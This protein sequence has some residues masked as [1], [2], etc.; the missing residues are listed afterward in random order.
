MHHA[1]RWAII[2][3]FTVFLYGCSSQESVS[4]GEKVKS[5]VAQKTEKDS[6]PTYNPPEYK[7]DV[8]YDPP[9]YNVDI[10]Y[11]PPD[12]QVPEYH[13]PNFTSEVKVIQPNEHQTWIRIPDKILFDFDSS[14]L[15][16]EADPVLKKIAESLKEAKGY[17]VKIY[18]HTDNKGSDDYNL[19]LSKRRAEA[20]RKALV[21]RFGV[22]AG[23]LSAEGLGERHPVASNDTEENRQ[24]NR[25]VEFLVQPKQK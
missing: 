15:R 6:G 2:L 13:P 16:P 23:I 12:Y 4:D 8:D 14:Q 24:K 21:E 3:L 5:E 11:D 25:R 7:I 17:E 9:E 19:K 1:K 18:G 20:V 22:S 10:E